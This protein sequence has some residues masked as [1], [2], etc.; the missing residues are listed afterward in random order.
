MKRILGVIVVGL[1]AAGG[2]AA[3]ND[4]DGGGGGGGGS[5]S[6]ECPLEALEDAEGTVE[7]TMW[8]GLNQANEEAL[9]ALVT[10]F[11]DSQEDVQV[12][13]VNQSSYDDIFEKFLTGLTTGDL[14]DVVQ[15]QEILLQQYIDT[16][17]ILP[18]QA[19]IDA[20][21]YDTSDYVERAINY[22]TVED[23]TWALPFNPSNPVFLYNKNM[24]REAGLDPE[25]PPTTLTE[26]R[27]T[28]ETIAESGISG[29][30]A[31]MAIKNDPWFLE[32]WS[33]KANELFANNNNGREARATEVL[34]DNDTGLEIFTFLQDMVADGLAFPTSTEGGGAIDNLLAVGGLRAAMTI[35]SSAFLGTAQQALERGE[36]GETDPGIGPMPGPEGDGGVLVGGASLMIVNS[37]P[38]EKQAAAWEFMKFATSPEQQA[39]F[40]AATGYI[41]VRIS[42][43][44]NP[45]LQQR[46]EVVP[47]MK[48]A[49]DQ[50]VEGADTDATAGATIGPFKAIRDIVQEEQEE[51][52]Q[53]GKDAAQA[54]A[55]AA[56][57]ANDEITDYNDRIGAG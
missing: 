41:P 9:Q 11:N 1:L 32:Q 23:T 5:A 33:A 52:L 40:A 36:Y 29:L 43:A 57:R 20:E 4:D 17:T 45:V 50:L 31:P 13:L 24:F 2:L 3:C 26:L 7:I 16:E 51:M 55:D 21:D 56:Q 47:G 49:Y 14:P 22:Y 10:S 46:W 12:N 28:A 19:C 48:V 15:G 30:D 39:L 37:S 35:D 18:A 54:L 34:F 42:S 38:P 44:D 53:G 25:D 6:A 27:A 8:H